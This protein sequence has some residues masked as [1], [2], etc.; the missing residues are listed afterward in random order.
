MSRSRAS[1]GAA[2]RSGCSCPARRLSSV[3]L[4][5]RNRAEFDR[6]G[7]R[8]SILLVEDDDGVRAY[9]MEALRELGYR[10][11]EASSG[12]AALNVLDSAPNLDLLL[13]DV[14]MPG[15]YNG[16]ELADEAPE[17]RPGLRVLYM[18]G[19]SRDAI[20]RH[21]RLDPGVHLLG[22]PFSL[23]ELA[24]KVRDRLDAAQL[25]VALP[26]RLC[27]RAASAGMVA[28]SNRADR[29]MFRPTSSPA[30]P[31]SSIAAAPQASRSR[32]RN[33]APAASSRDC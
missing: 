13:T 29:T 24:A 2:R 6:P 4:A 11:A 21:G 16:R 15:E 19:Y 9:A 8:E 31:R 28:T 25:N 27:R 20:M 1:P 30:P 33:P 18:T 7:G 12:K 32:P 23:E 26:F 17:R 5:E 3:G 14:V 22:K 10:V